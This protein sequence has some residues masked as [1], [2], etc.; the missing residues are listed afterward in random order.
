MGLLQGTKIQC[1]RCEGTHDVL[2]YIPLQMQPMHEDEC[3]QI[4]KCPACRW[5]FAPLPEEGN[6]L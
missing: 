2:A 4:Y 5:L 3:A 1:P 6:R